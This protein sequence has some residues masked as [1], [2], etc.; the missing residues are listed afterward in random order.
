MFKG[1]RREKKSAP[2]T[3]KAVT[4]SLVMTV[5]ALSLCFGILIGGIDSNANITDIFVNEPDEIRSS[6]DLNAAVSYD[7]G[8]I[9]A[10]FDLSDEDNIK[11]D[12]Y[13]SEHE[14][15]RQIVFR[16]DGELRIL[17][18]GEKITQAKKD[19]KA[20]KKPPEEKNKLKNEA[21]S[22]KE[23][24]DIIPILEFEYEQNSVVRRREYKNGEL[25]ETVKT[26]ETENRDSSS[27]TR[28]E[29]YS[30]NAD[31][32]GCVEYT[33]DRYGN[34]T[35]YASYNE[36]N[37]QISGF[38][39]SYTYDSNANIMSSSVTD[40]GGDPIEC[41]YRYDERNNIV[42]ASTYN[43]DLATSVT[44][45]AYVYDSKS[46][47][48]E[49]TKSVTYPTSDESTVTT[50][51]YEYNGDNLIS[52]TILD[53]SGHTLFKGSYAYSESNKLVRSTETDGAE[54]KTVTLGYETVS[55]DLYK[56]MQ[57][58]TQCWDV[59]NASVKS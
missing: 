16:F 35:F 52:K 5:V 34:P 9:T 22:E 28:K 29:I 26:T 21:V 40:Y 45:Y 31:F 33:E 51:K 14:F 37:I 13:N 41:V 6:D 15:M 57:T 56:K 32:L 54:E 46:R 36:N 17:S 11:L 20:D 43:K 48:S 49:A 44:T 38:S 24:S 1:Q 42:Y 3:K 50:E 59:F 19:E 4:S 39:R 47:V 2:Q 10:V 30:S 58:I 55:G 27:E 8:E 12:Y 53:S 7:N 25:Y 18:A 23:N